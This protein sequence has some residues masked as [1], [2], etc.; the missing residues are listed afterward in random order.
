MIDCDHDLSIARQ[1]KALGVSR[2]AVY[3]RHEETQSFRLVASRGEPPIFQ[4]FP[5]GFA[6]VEMLKTGVGRNV[7]GDP[8][9]ALTWLVNELSGLGLPLEEGMVVSTGTCV[10][11]LPLASGDHVIGDFGVLGR[12]E[13][14]FED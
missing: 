5:A 7:L 8:R 3:L 14:Q 2:G 10:K 9:V 1:A 6:L 13:A 11:P 12:I 4:E